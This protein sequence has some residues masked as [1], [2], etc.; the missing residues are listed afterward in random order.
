[1]LSQ[2]RKQK[3]LVPLTLL[4]A[5]LIILVFLAPSIAGIDDDEQIDFHWEPP[6]NAEAAVSYYHIY[7]SVDGGEYRKIDTTLDTYYTIQ[8]DSGYTYRMR[9]AGVN[10]DGLEGPHSA[11]SEGILCLP[12]SEETIVFGFA[13]VQAQETPGQLKIIWETTSHLQPANF[14]IYRRELGSDREQLLEAEIHYDLTSGASEFRYY[15]MDRNISVGSAYRYTIT[16]MDPGGNGALAVSLY[17]EIAGPVN[18]RLYQNYPNP[19]NSQ[20]T[21][22]YQNPEAGWVTVTIYNARGQKVCT[23]VDAFEDPGLHLVHWDGADGMGVP[24]A[25]GVYF[26]CMSSGSFADVKKLTVIR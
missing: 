19:F 21:I 26:C 11:N 12:Q 5:G 2:R 15:C 17:T 3:G 13:A 1:L 6:V 7:L 8:G 25:S 4:S 16:A 9:V 23:L 10:A 22:S 14:Q 20:T 18:H 24:V